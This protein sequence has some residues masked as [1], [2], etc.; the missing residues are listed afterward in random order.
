M[1]LDP[2][3]IVTLIAGAIPVG[4]V[5]A[6]FLYISPLTILF[7]AAA[8]IAMLILVGVKIIWGRRLRRSLRKPGPQLITL[9]SRLP[10]PPV[11]DFL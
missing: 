10:S 9:P 1:R 4:A 8:L 2:L 3:A 6:F 5:G 11:S 7:V